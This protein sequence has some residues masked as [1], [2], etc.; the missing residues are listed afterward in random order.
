MKNLYLT[1]SLLWTLFF[2]SS[3]ENPFGSKSSVP[4]NFLE[5][6]STSTTAVDSSSF[7]F[8]NNTSYLTLSPGIVIGGTITSP[9]TVEGWFYCNSLAPGSGPRPTLIS[10]SVSGNDGALTI[11]VDSGIVTVDANGKA[12]TSF[13]VPAMVANSW[14]YLAVSRDT[15]GFIQVWMGKL[16]DTTA[17]ASTTGRFT[18][19]ANFE[20]AGTSN[21]VGSFVPASR[22]TRNSYISNLRITNTNL[23]LTN[24]ATIPMPTSSFDAVTGTVLLLNDDTLIDK[25]GLHTLTAVGSVTGS[26]LGPL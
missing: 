13:T 6:T 25:S 5:S 14:Y 22:D 17:V 7:F 9:F 18:S 19:I 16:G 8:L 1:S 15:S 4:S 11:N 21:T 24:A 3:C 26:T 2:L 10:T 23:F 20:F 12:A